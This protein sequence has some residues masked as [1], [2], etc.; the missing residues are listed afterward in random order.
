MKK[1]KTTTKNK[2][3]QNLENITTKLE[4]YFKIGIKDK[5]YHLAA[6]SFLPLLI[7][8]LYI[9]IF[10]N[11]IQKHVAL[12]HT[13]PWGEGVLS[14]KINIY[15]IPLTSM[16]ISISYVALSH[17]AKKFYF[18]YMSRIILW[19]A[20]IS[21]TIAF[22]IVVNIIYTF[23]PNAQIIPKPLRNIAPFL[24]LTALG[25]VVSYTLTSKFTNLATKKGL[26]TDPNKHKHPAMI[27][28]KPSARGAGFVFATTFSILSLLIVQ[29]TQV[30]MGIILSVLIC[31]IIGILDDIQNSFSHTK[32][33]IVE[34]PAVRLIFLLPIPVMVMMSYGITAQYVNNPLNGEI[35]LSDL[36]FKLFG[37]E[38]APL[39]YIF[40]LV[41][42]L[43]VMNM[44]SWSNGVDGQ[45]AGIAGISTLTIGII[46]LRL[47]EKDPLQISIAQMAFLASGLA[48]GTVKY[49]W[50]PSKIMWGYGAIS[51]G[52]LLSAL[53]IVSRAKIAASVLVILIPFLDGLITIIRRVLQKRNPL[54]GDRGHLHHLLLDRGWKVQQVALF[55]WATTAFCGLIS[56]ISAE[57]SLALVTL[58][59]GIIVACGIIALNIR[60]PT[61]VATKQT[62]NTEQNI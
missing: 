9:L 6:L 32:L 50:H 58:T 5:D 30:T 42:T 7:S 54:K 34:N 17:F 1:F 26:I 24:P 10:F 41:W 12:W 28:T 13:K 38:I 19:W 2:I 4:R 51:I 44:I 47:I 60:R 59:I 25:F 55:Y 20:I 11:D 31:G 33:K 43:G 39:P 53:S 46:T 40:T 15:L 49:T 3:A 48:F 37:K 62:S 22:F 61:K 36:N 56:V 21:N 35:M 18:S 16:V 57:K 8:L 45:F 52:L 29:K 23:A 14:P 27:L